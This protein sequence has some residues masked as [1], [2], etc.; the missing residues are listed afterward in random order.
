MENFE[1]Q[2][3]KELDYVSLKSNLLGGIESP[4]EVRLKLLEADQSDNTHEAANENLEF[5]EDEDVENFISTQSLEIQESYFRFLGFT[6]WHIA[7]NLMFEDKNVEGLELFK[8]SVQNSLK[9]KGEESWI[10]Y[11]KGTIAYLEKDIERLRENIFSVTTSEKNKVIL[12]RMLRTLESGV[13]PD[14]KT[15]Y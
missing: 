12:E 11:G 7:Q 1:K 3:N 2:N 15:D 6:Q 8:K 14:Y 13:E 5:L 4:K 9:G 10:A